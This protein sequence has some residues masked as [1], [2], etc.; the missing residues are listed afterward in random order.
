MRRTR[1][2]ALDL[3]DLRP[4]AAPENVSIRTYRAGDAAAWE[5]VVASFYGRRPASV[6]FDRLLRARP[7]YRPGRLVVASIGDAPAAFAMAGYDPEVLPGAGLLVWPAVEGAD[8]QLILHAVCL[9]A[10][11]RM[12]DEGRRCAWLKP[13]RLPSLAAA[14]SALGFEPRTVCFEPAAR[15]HTEYGGRIVPLRRWLGTRLVGESTGNT[16]DA[17]ADESLY[18]PTDL[19]SASIVP[20]RVRCAE[21][22]PFE[23]VYRAGRAPIGRGATVK[24]W[25][26]GQGA[27]GT[28]PQT[29]D[30]SRPGYV[31]VRAPTGVVADA[32]CDPVRVLSVQRGENPPGGAREGDLI[33]GPVT[34]GFRVR[35]GELAEGDEVRLYVGR[36]GGF[37]WKAVAGRKQFHVVVD[38]GHGEPRMRLPEPVTVHMEP[39]EPHHLDLF[40]P[41][42]AARE[43]PVIARV[44]VRDRY[45]NRVSWDGPLCIR[46][47]A[48]ELA[49]TVV[50][51]AGAAAIGSMGDGPIHA[52]AACAAL[53]L[54]ARSNTC[55]PL[56]ATGMSVFFGD[57][58]AHDFLSTA[59]GF[60]A[61]CYLW[62]RDEKRLDFVSIPTQVHRWIDNEKWAVAKHM[63][64][65]FLEEG[66]FVTLL[67]FEWQ[68]SEYGDKVIHYLGGDMPYLPVDDPRYRSPE[69]LYEALRGT[70]AFIVSHHPGYQMHLHVPG[71]RWDSVRTDVDRLVELWS[72][73]GSSEG[74]D[75][76]DRPLIPPRRPSGVRDALDQGL[77]MG[78]VGGSDTHT[79][80]PGGSIGEPRP[81]R[82]GLCGV[83]AQSLTRRGLFE[84]FRARRTF[85]LTGARV[86]LWFSVNGCPLGSDIPEAES[87]DI[88]VEAWAP[89]PIRRVEL[90][91]DGELLAE[92][93]PGLEHVSSRFVDRGGGRRG[94]WYYCRVVQDDGELA[95]SS[96][97]W[98]G[99]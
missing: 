30:P 27:L 64:E 92:E 85:A 24:F 57:L 63:N 25:M 5:R 49:A 98:V 50:D 23:L 95:V 3:E 66:R 47:G 11:R 20:Q 73:H 91:R 80:R 67:S 97:V 40:L 2:L 59:E 31:E 72:M 51:G 26:A 94:A 81:Y 52:E 48:S 93:S 8:G 53:G 83:W 61:D 62:A 55:V 68:H 87:Y 78:F 37:T 74:R 6:S 77:R 99:L 39:L 15:D 89:R 41:G 79:G 9:E 71:T 12:A 96:P 38:Q 29:E 44:S 36:R 45:D 4:A 54:Q 46:A 82:G 16:S 19:G 42:S 56:K 13:T 86:V 7:D 69:G 88:N 76:S 70:D 34:V 28:A 35:S 17:R 22:K 84:A 10:L 21:A 58:H 32:L 33:V 1:I 65:Y 90:L 18:R 43:A 14:A 60:P 75:P